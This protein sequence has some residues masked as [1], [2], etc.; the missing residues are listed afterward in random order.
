M[1]NVKGAPALTRHR[2]KYGHRDSGSLCGRH[3]T[4]GIKSGTSPPVCNPLSDFID[5]SLLCLYLLLWV[6]ILTIIF[7]YGLILSRFWESRDEK[8]A[9]SPPSLRSISI[10]IFKNFTFLWLCTDLK[11]T[12]IRCEKVLKNL[13]LPNN[14]DTLPLI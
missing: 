13:I 14:T 3:G 7:Y 5:T 6:Y 1:H 4:V 10:K 2:R 12:N 11:R 8:C 9:F